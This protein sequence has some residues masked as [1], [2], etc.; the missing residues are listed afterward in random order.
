MNLAHVRSLG[1]WRRENS[2]ETILVELRR[3]MAS[4][5]NRKTPQPPEGSEYPPLDIGAVAKQR[6]A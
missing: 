6:G 1:N 5:G 2:L 3:E 4:P